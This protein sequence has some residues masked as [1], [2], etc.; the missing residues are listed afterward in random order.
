MWLQC[1]TIPRLHA[2]CLCGFLSD[3]FDDSH[4]LMTR[5]QR[6]P[7][8]SLL[9]ESAAILLNVATTET[10]GLD[11]KQRIAGAYFGNF[12]FIALYAAIIDLNH[13]LRF[14]AVSISGQWPLMPP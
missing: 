12:D 3:F 8:Q 6:I 1:N 4:R 9:S 5:N 10:T 14:H 2:P 13:H 11:A 7:Y